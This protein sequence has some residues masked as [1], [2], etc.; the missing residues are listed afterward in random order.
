MPGRARR[1]C[2]P[3]TTGCIRRGDVPADGWP[4]LHGQ[5]ALL[6]ATVVLTCTTCGDITAREAEDPALPEYCHCGGWAWTG[7][8]AEPTSR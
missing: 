8:L 5:V 7:E 4:V 6:P 1:T 3:V 2:G